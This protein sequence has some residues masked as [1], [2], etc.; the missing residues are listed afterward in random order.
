M[1]SDLSFTTQV[2]GEHQ[3]ALSLRGIPLKKLIA[4]ADFVSTV[5]LSLMGK[6]PLPDAKALLNALL[7]AALD[8]GLEP[9]T[10]FVPRVAMSSGA[11]ITTA[12]ATSI[13]VLGPKHGAAVSSAMELFSQVLTNEQ[14]IE[15]AARRKVLE[16]RNQNRR[17]PGFG[18]PKGKKTDER[19]QALFAMARRSKLS[20]QALDAAL[21]IETA[22]EEQTGRA[23]PINIDGALA[24]ILVAL[25]FDP[26][27]GNAL[28]AVARAAGSIAHCIEEVRQNTGV[29]RLRADQIEYTA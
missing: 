3:G 22:L 13:L 24:A 10:G 11:E 1:S 19:A 28:Y 9:A 20:L 5:Y 14:D 6:Q 8:P 4:E 12:V 18:H 16:Y 2:S 15:S 7:V 27:A 26:L 21:Y 25:G 17:V 23:L 29:R